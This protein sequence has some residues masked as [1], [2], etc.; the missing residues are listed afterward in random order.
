M[1]SAW[2]GPEYQDKTMSKTIMIADDEER[3][4]SLL[5]NYLTQ[6]GY[7]V[8]TAGNGREALHLAR[9]EKPDVVLLDVM[10]PE[11]DGFE[12]LRLYRA[13][14]PDGAVI[15]ITARVDDADAVLGL[16]LGADD[17]VTKPFSPRVLV[18]RVRAMLRRA[19]LQAPT[20][21]LLRAADVTLDRA[22]RQVTVAERPVD[23]TPSE[24]DLLSTLMAAPGRVYTRSELLEQVQGI[25]Y[26]G[27]E[28]TIDVHIRNLRTKIE[29]TPREPRYIRTVYGVG[30]CFAAE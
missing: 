27:Y 10:M 4:R 12:F 22:T 14:N 7:R 3:M 29:P 19:G 24:F 15:V 20:A 9:H 26:E 21:S 30:Y 8:V 1:A 17:Y 18:A 6:E 25:A 28:R 13:E 2:N 16:E 11:M 23:L 5:R